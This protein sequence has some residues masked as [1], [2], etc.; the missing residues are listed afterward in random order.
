MTVSSWL[1][2]TCWVWF[3]LVMVEKRH[4]RVIV[5]APIML[6][7]AI[8]ADIVRWTAARVVKAVKGFGDFLCTFDDVEKGGAA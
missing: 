2:L 5:F 4:M 3:V 6:A 8:P 1:L 7:I